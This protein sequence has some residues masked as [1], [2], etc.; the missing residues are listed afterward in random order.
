MIA[1]H[2]QSYNLNLSTANQ[3]AIIPPIANPII[4]FLSCL[5]FILLSYHH[6]E[7]QRDHIHSQ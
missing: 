2:H 7:Q 1:Y 6:D 5:L 3:L 4:F